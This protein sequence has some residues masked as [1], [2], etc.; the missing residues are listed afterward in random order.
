MAATDKVT[1]GSREPSPWR[2]QGFGRKNVKS[3]KDPIIEP[4][5]QG[6][7]RL[8]RITVG[9]LELFDE[10]GQPVE[11]RG[12]DEPTVF[13]ALVR[14]ALA[15]EVVLDGY[16]TR[17][18]IPDKMPDYR[19]SSPIP[20]AG[21]MASQMFVGR[22]RKSRAMQQIDAKEK[23]R[24]LGRL[25]FVAIDI[26]SLDGQV[27]FDIPQLER[28]R[29]LESALAEGDIVRRSAFVRLPIDPWLAS[30]RAVGFS[31]IAFKAANSRYQPGAASDDWA[32]V[33]IPAT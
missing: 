5:W 13:E 19:L 4:L 21:E 8:A 17:Q 30:W 28:K 7:R 24:P 29:L 31:R 9:G 2:A 32:I 22:S 15:D 16:L 26:L 11:P 3:I 14:A 1:E 27:L 33:Q 25:A 12:T 20:S 23:A 10:L 18:A 6:D